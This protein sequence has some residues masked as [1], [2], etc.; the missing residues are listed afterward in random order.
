M[1]SFPGRRSVPPE[2]SVCP[3][4]FEWGRNQNQTAH[5]TDP[6]RVSMDR[7][8]VLLPFFVCV[9]GPVSRPG[10][11]LRWG[12]ARSHAVSLI[13]S[14]PRDYPA[15]WLRP[16]SQNSPLPLTVACPELRVRCIHVP[17]SPTEAETTRS[18]AETSCFCLLL[19]IL[20]GPIH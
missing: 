19:H 17:R 18:I 1:Q 3:A 16:P 11:E 5:Q 20:R 14:P 13:A 7:R 15:V 8:R 2:R 4:H 12:M 6:N 10:A 9:R